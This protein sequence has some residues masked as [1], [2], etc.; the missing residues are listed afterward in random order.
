[1]LRERVSRDSATQFEARGVVNRRTSGSVRSILIQFTTCK[2]ELVMATP[3]FVTIV[4]GQLLPTARSIPLKIGVQGL[5]VRAARANTEL[6]RRSTTAKQP[7]LI[8]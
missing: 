4:V 7:L 8:V 6:A 5:M 2:V 1:M 3:L